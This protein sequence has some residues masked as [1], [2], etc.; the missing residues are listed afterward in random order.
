MHTCLFPCFGTHT[1]VPILIGTKN[2]NRMKIEARNTGLHRKTIN[3]IGSLMADIFCFDDWSRSS[4]FPHFT[5]T[6]GPP[7]NFAGDK[8]ATSGL[9]LVCIQTPTAAADIYIKS[10]VVGRE[11]IL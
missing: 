1:S 6:G 4:K 10:K 7:M 11:V 3:D 9:L 5:S 8:R 2:K